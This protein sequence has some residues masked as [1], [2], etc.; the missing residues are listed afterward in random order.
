MIALADCNNFF[1]SCELLKKPDLKGKP[2]CVLSNC[3][4]CVI[5]R[6]NEAKQIGIKMGMPL[7]MAKREFP[8]AVYLSSDMS[9]Y[10]EISK[11][12]RKLF[13]EFSPSVEIYSI[14]EAFID[15]TGFDKLYGITYEEVAKELHTLV[16]RRTGIPVSVG[17]ANSK[18]L[19]KAVT[20]IAKKNS[21]YR[22]LPEEN[23]KIILRNYPIEKIW[24]VG[25]NISRKLRS[26]GIFTAQDIF[27]KD[28]NFFKFH[29]GKKGLE[30]KAGLE[31]ID[32]LPVVSATDKPKSVQKTS[33]FTDFTNDKEFLKN[34]VLEHLHNACQ[35]IR[36]N[37]LSAGMVGVMLRAK[38][39]QVFYDSKK[40]EYNSNS[41]FLLN[42]KAIEIFET[43]Y[44]PNI[45]Y[46]S[47]GVT[48]YNLKDTEIIQI[49]LLDTYEKFNK[50]SELI[51][52]I[53]YKYGKNSLQ[54]G[55]YQNFANKKPQN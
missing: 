26:F 10:I 54:L 15:V 31:G 19:C 14:D 18:V 37:N 55:K 3:D 27:K 46:R 43:I 40:L 41:E 1:V 38:D 8:E 44:N 13:F 48:L 20:D 47:T 25:K 35:K 12:I 6:S 32:V 28:M 50:I 24:G 49:P 51:D 4:G 30:L 16:M 11:R 2:V 5:S 17:I 7:F 29:F 36:K 21:F 9:F 53:E 33:S 45:I 42:K 23:I 52:K 39:F 34:S 22:F